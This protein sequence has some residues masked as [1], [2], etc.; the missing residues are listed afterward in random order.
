MDRPW[1]AALVVAAV[2]AVAGL[3]YVTGFDGADERATTLTVAASGL[4]K[5]VQADIKVN[6]AG[7]AH[8]YSLSGSDTRS[9][10]PGNYLITV[11]AVV[12]GEYRYLGAT[13]SIVVT[14]ARGANTKSKAEYRISV[15]KAARVAPSGADSPIEQVGEKSVTL[16]PSAYTHRLKPG[17]ILVSAATEAQPTPFAAAVTATTEEAGG[18]VVADVVHVPM[19]SVMPKMVVQINNPKPKPEERRIFRA[20][21]AEQPEQEASEEPKPEMTEEEVTLGLGDCGKG[22]AAVRAGFH[23][24]ETAFTSEV[25]IQW[26]RLGGKVT[27][28]NPFG[29]DVTISMEVKAPKKMTARATADV[30]GK[31]TAQFVTKAALTCSRETFEMKDPFGVDKGLNKACKAAGK[32]LR[33]GPL[34]PGC[35]LTF[36]GDVEIEASKELSTGVTIAAGIDTAASWNFPGGK[37]RRPLNLA[38]NPAIHVDDKWFSSP[39]DAKVSGAV[40]MGMATIIE[41]SIGGGTE[42]TDLSLEY[43]MWYPRGVKYETTRARDKV[44]VGGVIEHTMGLTLDLPDVKILDKIPDPKAE[45]KFVPIKFPIGAIQLGYTD[46]DHPLPSSADFD[47]GEEDD[48]EGGGGSV[49][50]DPQDSGEPDLADLVK[51]IDRQRL[52]IPYPGG[53]CQQST[54]DLDVPEVHDDISSRN[55]IGY[56]DC[57][58]R[59]VSLGGRNF[60]TGP[61]SPPAV[62]TE[63]IKWAQ[64]RATGDKSPSDFKRGDTFCAITSKGNVAWLKFTGSTDVGERHP[65]LHFELTLWKKDSP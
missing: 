42:K 20:S 58:S 35:K 30:H 56:G 47:F 9:V 34:A 59:E 6:G 4:P 53:A 10:A 63:C 60:G 7:K 1:I 64:R 52:T 45:F 29:K 22:S 21:L 12:H 25:D 26:Y 55:E 15:H 31:M 46:P 23:D 37:T 40:R 32:I 50:P 39:Q 8:D 54:A 2:A 16:G 3:L 62:P 27:I 51:T 17:H 18:R 43:E 14:A 33:L 61:N 57:K 48:K 28:P 5:G 38:G 65:D 19:S 11:G 24:F 36:K 41:A 44:D 49:T 13:D